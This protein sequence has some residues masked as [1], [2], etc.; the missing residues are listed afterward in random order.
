MALGEVLKGFL[1]V[2]SKLI[3]VGLIILGLA[4]AFLMG[5][6]N[7]I[8]VLEGT[9]SALTAMG[10]YS[11]AKASYLGLRSVVSKHKA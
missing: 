11:G 6:I 2:N 7:S 3:P 1:G 8:S 4:F 10:L 9:V 5:G